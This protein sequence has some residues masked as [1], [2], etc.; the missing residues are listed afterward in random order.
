MC[1]RSTVKLCLHEIA[2]QKLEPQCAGTAFN[3]KSLI[4]LPGHILNR[5]TFSVVSQQLLLLQEG[6]GLLKKVLSDRSE[7]TESG[8][9]I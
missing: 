6:L 5:G 7:C 1:Y 4:K 3:F 8:L 9:H 2:I